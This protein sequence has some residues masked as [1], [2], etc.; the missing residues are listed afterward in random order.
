MKKKTMRTQKKKVIFPLACLIINLKHR[1]TFI[2][3]NKFFERHVD[4]SQVSNIK[5]SHY[6]LSKDFDI[7]MTN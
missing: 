4:V 7:F 5:N 3:Q 2:L 6:V 1:T